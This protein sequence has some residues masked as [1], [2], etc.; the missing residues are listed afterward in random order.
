MSQSDYATPMTLKLLFRDGL[1]AMDLQLDEATVD[2]QLAYIELLHK[3]TQAYNLTAI[4]D[5]R[6]MVSKHLLDSLAVLPFIGNGRVADVG[7]GA[8]LPGI[9]LALAKAAQTFA[10]VES[11][12]KKTRFLAQ[13]KIELP[14][15]N[16][17]VINK[18]VEAYRPEIYFD[19]VIARAFAPGWAPSCRNDHCADNASRRRR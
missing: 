4:S 6:D 2:L 18:R 12:T 10:L 9:P 8:G 14:L 5:P 13:A 16:V 11:A 1:R 3:W 15:D 7:S 17:E 19:V